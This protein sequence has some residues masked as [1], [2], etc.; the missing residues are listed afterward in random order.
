LRQKHLLAHSGLVDDH[1]GDLTGE[2]LTHIRD[3]CRVNG[4]TDVLLERGGLLSQRIEKAHIELRKRDHVALDWRA[5]RHL[6][7]HGHG[8]L[9]LRHRVSLLHLL[10][11]HIRLLALTAKLIAVATTTTVVASAASVVVAAA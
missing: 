1:S 6:H 4:V 9:L 10:T 11:A 3:N 8:H 5:H 7:L 2:S